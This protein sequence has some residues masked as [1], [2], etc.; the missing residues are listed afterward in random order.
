MYYFPLF[1]SGT[2]FHV[3]VRFTDEKY[4]DDLEYP[5]NPMYA[6]MKKMLQSAVGSFTLNVQ[7][8]NLRKQHCKNRKIKIA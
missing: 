6:S 8:F 2:T 7:T 1:L 4:S 3:A 5:I